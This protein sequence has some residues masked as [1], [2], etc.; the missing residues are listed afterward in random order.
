MTVETTFKEPFVEGRHFGESQVGNFPCRAQIELVVV[1]GMTKLAV[2]GK[3]KQEAVVNRENVVTEGDF[4]RFAPQL[5]R[6]SAGLIDRV[7]GYKRSWMSM[8]KGQRLLGVVVQYIAANRAQKTLTDVIKALGLDSNVVAVDSIANR[9]RCASEA[10]PRLHV[11]ADIVIE[12]LIL[13]CCGMGR[14]SIDK[15]AGLVAI[16]CIANCFGT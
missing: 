2:G 10:T 9:T 15:D 11:N 16:G 14:Y 12:N 8:A 1:A 5:Y 6:I 3:V 4:V 7:A 13:R